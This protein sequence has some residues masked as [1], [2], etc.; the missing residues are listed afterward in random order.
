MQP[1]T[2]IALLAWAR[3]NI[4]TVEFLCDEAA[5]NELP[6]EVTTPTLVDPAECEAESLLL[7]CLECRPGGLDPNTPSRTREWLWR[8]LNGEGVAEIMAETCQ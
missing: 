7:S 2:T 4:P 6:G 1:P 3:A 8:G 5:A